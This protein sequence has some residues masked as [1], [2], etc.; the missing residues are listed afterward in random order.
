MEGRPECETPPIDP[1]GFYVLW[2]RFGS[3]RRL[4][5]AVSGGAD[6]MA[7]MRLAGLLKSSGAADV[8][9]A[10]VDHGL[11]REA[12][13]EAEM[14]G[15]EAGALGLAHST[16]AWTGEKPTS[17][18]QAAAREARYRLLIANALA[19]GADALMT[20]HTA[21]DQA[22]TV[23]MRLARG[24]GPRGLS[25]MAAETQIAAGASLPVRLLRPLL[26][27]R[28]ASLR[29]YLH[30]QGAVFVDDPSNEDFAYERVRVRSL[31]GRLETAGELGVGA[32]L[33]TAAACSDAARRLEAVENERFAAAGGRFDILG[34]AS[35]DASIASPIEAALAARIIQAVGGGPYAPNA[36]SAADALERALAGRPATLGGAILAMREGRLHFQREPAGILGRAGVAGLAP[37]VLS[38]GERA[39]WDGRFIIANTFD[40]AATLRPLGSRAQTLAASKVEEAALAAAPSLWIDDRLVA[41]PGEG[42]DFEPLAEERFFRRANRFH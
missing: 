42:G 35:L 24:S 31:L 38:P 20:A 30:E 18:V 29:A 15:R 17:G 34:G 14:V 3:P 39:L 25:G 11:R 6:S 19:I 40:R 1:A 4:L 32:L 9:V 13:L 10:T 37:I 12:R 41:F 21:D 27:F 5:L 22:E 36:A 2:E 8:R 7:L 28:R 26:G 16:L 23:L 33:Q